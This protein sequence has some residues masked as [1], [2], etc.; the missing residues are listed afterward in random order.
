MDTFLENA[1]AARGVTL[2]QHETKMENLT[3]ISKGGVRILALEH[4]RY[5]VE[6][7]PGTYNPYTDTWSHADA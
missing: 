7:H 4:D 2:E 5:T 1:L 6:G 3:R